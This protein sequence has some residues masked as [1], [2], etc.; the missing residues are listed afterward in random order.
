MRN[1]I[2]RICRWLLPMFGVSAA[3]SCDNVIQ[4]PDM[5]GCPP[6]PE[7]GVPVMEYRMSGKVVDSVSGEPIKGI[8]VTHDNPVVSYDSYDAVYTEDDGSFVIESDGFPSDMMN[9]KFTDVDGDDNGGDYQTKEMTV[10]LS[11]AEAGEGN[12]DYGD[13]SAENIEVILEKKPRP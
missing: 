5:Y 4:S 3:I 1:L 12:W 11:R 7:Y 13:Y 6:A 2:L 8:A 9:L 10:S